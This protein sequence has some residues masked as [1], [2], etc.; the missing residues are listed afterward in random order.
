M[1]KFLQRMQV[2]HNYSDYEIKVIRYFILTMASEI[3][4]LIIMFT[5]FTCVGRFTEGLVCVATL[6]GLRLSGGGFH[7]KHYITCLFSS[8]LLVTAPIFLAELIAPNPIAMVIIMLGCIFI[9]YKM[10]PVVS[11]HRPKPTKEQIKKSRQ[12][13]FTFLFICLI[14]VAVFYTN[15]YIIIIFWLCVIHSAQLLIPKLDKG[16][17][18]YVI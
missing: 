13:N 16:G 4:K 9:A 1:E 3:S 7:C 10:V 6:M 12:F 14:A 11:Y 8:F 18:Y 5:F 15:H 17:K 2:S